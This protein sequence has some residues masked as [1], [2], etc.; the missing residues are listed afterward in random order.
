MQGQ[1]AGLG[2]LD[3]GLL[4]RGRLAVDVD[5]LCS[6]SPGPGPASFFQTY[7]YLGHHV[8]LSGHCVW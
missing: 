2:W 8:T 5:S 1:A 4:S 6:G 7:D 3:T